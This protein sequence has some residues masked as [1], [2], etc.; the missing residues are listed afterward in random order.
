MKIYLVTKGSK[1]LISNGISVFS[2][3]DS[4][5]PSY[6]SVRLITNCQHGYVEDFNKLM[7]MSFFFFLSV[8]EVHYFLSYS[9][10]LFSNSALSS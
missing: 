10:K 1:L 7:I 4:Q 5:N 8:Q 9:W 6:L 2:L 3:Q